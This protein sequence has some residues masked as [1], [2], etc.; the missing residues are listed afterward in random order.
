MS[1]YCE[2]FLVSVTNVLVLVLVLE[3]YLTWEDL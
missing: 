1:E 2:P 3:S